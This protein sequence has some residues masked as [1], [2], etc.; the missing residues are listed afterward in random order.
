MTPS[1]AASE[2]RAAINSLRE[3]FARAVLFS[4]F[5]NLLVLAPTLYMLEVYGRVVNSRNTE[6]LVMLTVLVI[7][8]Y[9]VMEFLD[10]VR[11]KLMDAAGVQL[12]HRLGER[13]FN[14]TFDARLRNLPAGVLPLND[15]RTV[16]GFLSSPALIA[17]M[18]APIALLF[19]VII[20]I[21]SPVLGAFVMAALV[22]M[23]VVG[24]V[25]ER[26]TKPPL[27]EAQKLAM[28]AQRY[29][30]T[31]L[32]NAQVIQA[33]G[34]MGHIRGR[35]LTRQRDFLARQAEASDHAGEGAALSKFIQIAQGSMVL[36]LAA[37]L[38]LIGELQVGGGAMIVAWTL[39]SR[40][41]GP[42]QMLISQWKT[43]VAARSAFSRLEAFLKALPV[44]ETGMPLPPPKGAL[45]VDG[46]VAG[47]PGNPA[48]ILR[49]VNFALAPGQALAV[50]GPT[51]SGKST[52]AR[53]LVGL[54]PAVSGKVRL[55]GVDVHTWN[56]QELGPHLGYLPQDNELFDGTLAENIARFGDVDG[57]K[58][59]EAARA[60]GLHEII[61]ALPEGYDTRIG[62]GGSVFSG[63]QRQRV[64]LARA[65]YNNPNFIVLDEPN[66]SLDESGDRALLQT[67]MA[68]KSRG[69]T[70]VIITHR[71]N[72]LAVVDRMLVLRDGQMQMFGP[73]DEVLAALSGKTKAAPAAA[74]ALAAT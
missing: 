57:A 37:W 3:Y 32:K 30:S 10:W 13:V 25:T 44:R 12:D 71:T 1:P 33:M 35:W 46:L 52:L 73:R 48:A 18:D 16:R 58:V 40:A 7:G 36:G 28:E 42:L 14:A 2:L 34:M 67:L 59:E 31:T 22:A 62:A 29:A 63:G 49:G 27:T 68:Q 56:K 55:D 17:V 9:V 65:I 64:A 26:R 21:V 51:A 15:L 70:L 61:T 47:A 4:V 54:W 8:L 74:P 41:L 60:V 43:V 5:T 19:I 45:S 38:T 53:L 23:L 66:S 72:V 69:A 24:Y 50:V 39:S 6:T 20:F 11:Q